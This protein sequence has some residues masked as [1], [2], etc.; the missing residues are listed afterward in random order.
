MDAT[1]IPDEL[2][3]DIVAA[4]NV[5]DT[6]AV[7]RLADISEADLY[8]VEKHAKEMQDRSVYG[9]GIIRTIVHEIRMLAETV[10]YNQ[11]ARLIH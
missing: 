4:L 9:G 5:L 11:G 7:S 1:K 2:G 10:R 3:Q 6:G 8:E